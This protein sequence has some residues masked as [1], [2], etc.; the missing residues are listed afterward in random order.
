MQYHVITTAAAPTL[1]A[2]HLRIGNKSTHASAKLRQTRGH[3]DDSP[4]PSL[5]SLGTDTQAKAIEHSGSAKDIVLCR[6]EH[7]RRVRLSAL[8]NG[9]RR[10][11]G[12]QLAG[13][14]NGSELEETLVTDCHGLA[15][16]NVRCGKGEGLGQAR[17]N[18]VEPEAPFL[19]AQGRS[20][21]AVDVAEGSTAL[22]ASIW[23][24]RW[25]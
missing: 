6:V 5:S 4:I 9:Q 14:H 16:E 3:L 24:C 22:K 20:V 17:C 19:A 2:W 1:T 23:S 13:R 12:S 8:G 11:T 15:V 10:E 21:G 7:V 25:R 18:Q